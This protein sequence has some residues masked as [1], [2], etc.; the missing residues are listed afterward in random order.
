MGSADRAFPWAGK[1]LTAATKA[2]A[3][4]VRSS[5]HRHQARFDYDIVAD[6]LRVFFGRQTAQVRVGIPTGRHMCWWATVTNV[7]RRRW[8]FAGL[9]V[10]VLG[11][12][13]AVWA[14]HRWSNSTTPV[15]VADAAA[16]F[17]TSAPASTP[18]A[19]TSLTTE[20]ASGGPTTGPTT[21]LTPLSTVAPVALVAPGVYRYL[22]SGSEGIDVLTKPEHHYPTESAVTVT[23]TAC[24]VRIEW[25]PLAERRE[26]FELCRTDGGLRLVSYGGFHTFFD[27]PDERSLTCPDN[28]WLV[29][30]TGVVADPSVTCTGSGLVD[31][32]A[33]TVAGAD[34]VNVDGSDVPVTVVHVAV[35]TTGATTGD[36]TR[37]LWL[38][39]NGLPLVWRD[40]GTGA[41]G[42]AV[43][44]VHYHEHMALRAASLQPV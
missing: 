1:A 17:Q 27:Q 13:V 29:P 16:A 26:W 18:A 7:T 24:G 43:G 8:L 6:S 9:A 14:A 5:V 33:T 39:A 41:S 11:G 34:V 22:T 36:A 32:R 37:E 4:A 28:A 12:A 35:T 42:S 15:S 40:E 19:T 10:L 21:G 25:K 3:A 30:P 20:A 31:V 44:I 23:A 38:A 2:T